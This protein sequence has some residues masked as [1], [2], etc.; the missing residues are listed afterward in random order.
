MS[1][2]LGLN[3]P[4]SR[5]EAPGVLPLPNS[6]KVWRQRKK[7]TEEPTSTVGKHSVQ[8]PAAN[9]NLLWPMLQTPSEMQ[10][11]AKWNAKWSKCRRARQLDSYLIY[12]HEIVEGEV[13]DH[14]PNL[15]N[16]IPKK[17]EEIDLWPS[18]P[19]PSPIIKYVNLSE[20]SVCLLGTM[21]AFFGPPNESGT[22][23]V[24]QHHFYHI[25]PAFGILDAGWDIF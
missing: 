16:Q 18:I 14:A 12:W 10:C 9:A 17:L 23:C 8:D 25:L 19:L 5:Q 3:R 7:G 6:C 21:G 2:K 22:E 15:W 13:I 24:L 11:N 4:E 20:L 1:P